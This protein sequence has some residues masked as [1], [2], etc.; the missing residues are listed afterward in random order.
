MLLRNRYKFQ[1]MC[2]YL[3]VLIGKTMLF[4]KSCS[5][6]ILGSNPKYVVTEKNPN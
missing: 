2:K 1:T 6:I 5:T 3:G 4:G